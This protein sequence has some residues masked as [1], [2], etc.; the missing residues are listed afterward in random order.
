MAQD[1]AIHNFGEK[2]KEN[3][4]E[5]YVQEKYNESRAKAI[6]MIDSG[7]YGLTDGDFWIM[8]NTTKT[9]GIMYS[10]LII[11]HK[12]CQKINDALENKVDPYAF[13]LDKQGYANSLVYTYQ[14]DDCFEVG[15]VSMSN[16]KQSYPYAMALKRCFDRVVLVKS[17]LAFAG[18]YSET[19]AESF[20][21]NE[22]PFADMS[23]EEIRKLR[24]TV[25]QGDTF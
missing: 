10:G 16:C 2:S 6:E 22:D 1:K 4:K 7:K 15:E 3:N 23:E 17:K 12:G 18:V 19:E 24:Q 14:D 20:K 25:Y 13:T 21:K 8:K 5:V 9:G 11:S